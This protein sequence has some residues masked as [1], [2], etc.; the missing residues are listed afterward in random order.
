MEQVETAQR[1]LDALTVDVGAADEQLAVL[2]ASRDE[3]TAAIDHELATV[4][5]ERA[6]I[7][8]VLP[9]DLLALYEKLR[10]LKGGVGAAPLRA[11]T[12]GGCQLSLDPSELAQIK[13]AGSDEVIRCEECQRILVRTGESGL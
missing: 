6:P 10:T 1:E 12:C 5:E 2:S 3:K 7:A 9:A 4:V 11:R 13:A 8:S